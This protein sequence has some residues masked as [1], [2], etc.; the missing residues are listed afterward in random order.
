MNYNVLL[1]RNAILYSA[2]PSELLEISNIDGR[3][4]VNMRDQ[5]R[6]MDAFHDV[7]ETQVTFSFLNII[8]ALENLDSDFVQLKPEEQNIESLF[9]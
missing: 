6:Q 4:N 9:F 2:S 5:S 8:D 7:F 3:T 1:P